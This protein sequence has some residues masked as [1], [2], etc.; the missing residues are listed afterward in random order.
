MSTV[1]GGTKKGAGLTAGAL[2]MPAAARAFPVK[3]GSPEMLY[4]F[5]KTQFWTQKRFPL[6]LELR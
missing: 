1:T 4:L 2:V 6:L 3:A 5:V